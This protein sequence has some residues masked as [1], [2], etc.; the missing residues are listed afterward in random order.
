MGKRAVKIL[1]GLIVVF[2]VTIPAAAL[3]VDDEILSDLLQGIPGIQENTDEIIAS[4]RAMAGTLA[5]YAGDAFSGL[6]SLFLTLFGSDSSGKPVTR[7]VI[8]L[9]PGSMSKPRQQT[10]PGALTPSGSPLSEPP[11]LPPKTE[12][13]QRSQNET[14]SAPSVSPASPASPKPALTAEKTSPPVIAKK[15]VRT[16]AKTPTR[17]VTGKATGTPKSK[18]APDPTADRDHKRGL[19]FYKGIGV[20]KDFKKAAQWFK[21]AAK[22]GHAGAQYNLGI[23]SYLGQGV[24]ED[25]SE[26]AKWFER[27]GDQDHPVA[28][29]NL[30]FMYFEGKGVKKD[31]LQAF[32]WI[33]RSANLGDEKAVRARETLQKALP[34][35]IFK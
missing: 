4:K 23:M 7:V 29:Y 25:F 28:Q 34:K 14:P 18:K 31:D 1:A 2:L 15:P 8:D 22:K 16:T 33:D 11:P 20:D 27:A 3:L 10:P 19:L 12:E 35:E 5:N 17:K 13:P 9:P 24:P 21:Q 6:D 30:G 32:M 26:A